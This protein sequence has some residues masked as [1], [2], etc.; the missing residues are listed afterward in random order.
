[1]DLH[2]PHHVLH[3]EDQEW[4]FVAIQ[5]PSV[6]ASC[7]RG[8]EPALVEARLGLVVDNVEILIQERHRLPTHVH[9]LVA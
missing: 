1:M 2:L 7:S 5:L 4:E 8:L 9:G 3:L 6:T